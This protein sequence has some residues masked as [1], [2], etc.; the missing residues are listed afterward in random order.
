MSEMIGSYQQVVTPSAKPPLKNHLNFLNDSSQLDLTA[1]TTAKQTTL[2]RDE[3]S[4]LVQDFSTE[5]QNRSTM[6][7]EF[8]GANR[9][10]GS[11][12]QF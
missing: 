2:M 3:G 7:H 9:S 12:H 6:S 1:A 11:N 10:Q 5:L 8:A 4:S